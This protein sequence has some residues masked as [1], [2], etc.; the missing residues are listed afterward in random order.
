MFGLA[1]RI[2]VRVSFR[3][4]VRFSGPVA[5]QAMEAETGHMKTDGR[6]KRCTLKGTVGD[7]VFAVLCACGR[8]IRKLLTHPR[9][10]P[11]WIAATFGAAMNPTTQQHPL[12]RLA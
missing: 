11:V 9:A 8:N 2:R 3:R 6:F 10:W 5:R 12:T 7:A 4:I 1:V